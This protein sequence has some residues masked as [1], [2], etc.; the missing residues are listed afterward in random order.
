M[1]LND[2][3]GALSET[4]S[5]NSDTSTEHNGYS[6]AQAVLDFLNLYYLCAL[7][8]VGVFGNGRNVYLFVRNNNKKEL[9]SPSYYLAALALAD[10]VFLVT[11]F[12]LWLGHFVGAYLLARP[13]FHHFLFYLSSVSSFISGKDCIFSILCNVSVVNVFYPFLCS[14]AN[15]GIHI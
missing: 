11:L 5:N 14:L 3:D 8:I 7:I 2:S 4:K 1:W 13:G 15:S 10:V 12:I 6:A 9:T